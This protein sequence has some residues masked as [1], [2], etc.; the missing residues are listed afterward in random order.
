M[1]LTSGCATTF[2]VSRLKA[3]EVE[4]K[5]LKA[6]EIRIEEAATSLPVGERLA[7]NVSWLGIPVGQITSTIEGI[8][9]VNGR[10]AYHHG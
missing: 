9:E 7:Y 3:I 4:G 5:R 6:D 1:L 2:R 10:R 8:Q